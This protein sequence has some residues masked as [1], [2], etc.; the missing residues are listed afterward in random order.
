M[1]GPLR[2]LHLEDNAMDAE[3]VAVTLA[4]EGVACEFVHAAS[5]E[6]FV[7]AIDGGSYDLILSDYALPGFDG[8]AAQVIAQER[9]P[10]VPF[11]FVSGTMG[12]EVAIDCLKRGAT[13]YVLKHRLPR[14]VPAVRRA[15]QEVQDRRERTRAENEVRRLNA[16]LEIALGQATSFLDSI[17]ENLP[18]MVYVKDARQLRFVRF[19]RACE[20]LFGMDRAHLIGRTAGELFPPA[21]ATAYEESDRVALQERRIVDLPEEIVPTRQLGPRVLHTRKMPIF[22]PSGEPRHVLCISRDVTEHRTAE[23]NARIS[24]LEAERANR[25]KSDFLSRMSHDLRTPLNAVLGFAQLL[26]L[27]ELPIEQA[28][29]VRQILTGGQHLLEL[30][31]EVLDI[32]RIES[33]Q[34]SLSPEPVDVPDIVRHVVQLIRPLAAARG[35]VV[36]V[37]GGADPPVFARADRQRLTQILLN[38][39]GN[40]VKYNRLGGSVSVQ[41]AVMGESTVRISVADTGPG[42]PSEKLALLFTPFERLGAEQSAVEGTGLGLAVAKGLA[43]AMGGSVGVFAEVDCGSTFWVELP[44]SSAPAGSDAPQEHTRPAVGT[45]ADAEPQGT[46]L[47]IEDN[48]S[49]VRLLERLLTRRRGVRLL[50]ESRGEDGIARARTAR[51]DLILL[52]LHLPDLTG[53][54][55]LRRL[56]ADPETR[57]LPVAVLSADAMPVQRQRLLAS[58][59]VAYLTKPVDIRQLLRL[60]DDRLNSNDSPVEHHD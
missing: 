40:A 59:A 56:W 37:A 13:D 53:E 27:E 11:L 44:R 38:F 41:A 24:K 52:D 48:H 31:N 36:S 22:G 3:L 28:D 45:A 1:T 25:A 34:L 54:E 30:I 46:I 47:Y 39:L 6:E 26:E 49:N 18:D 8:V 4:A 55:V 57:T 19:N 33:G 43:E 20:E 21:V 35:I 60:I 29:S 23:E 15:L 51:P 10:D 32:A 14:L 12:E 2:V 50:S 58:G 7:S 5:R 16:A 9:L 17:I 42:I